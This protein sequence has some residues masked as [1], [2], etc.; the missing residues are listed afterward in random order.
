MC[1]HMNKHAY[2]FTDTKTQEHVHMVIHTEI[3]TH[4]NIQIPPRHPK[5]YAYRQIHRHVLTDR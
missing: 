1:S 2:A 4:M 3:H 5:T